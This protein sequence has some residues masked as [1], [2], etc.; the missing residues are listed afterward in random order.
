MGIVKADAYGHGLL[1][2][3]RSLVAGGVDLLGVAYVHEG[4]SLREAGIRTPVVILCGAHGSD[5]IQQS[6]EKDLMP[7]LLDAFG[8]E[9]LARE[10]ERRQKTATVL[11]K[12]DTG[13]GRLGIPSADLPWIL[14][15]L[16]GLRSLR[17]KGLI[18]HLS[19]ADDPD[20]GF[21]HGQISAFQAAIEKGRAMG[22]DLTLNSLANS[23]G[24]IRFRESHFD[25]VRP[26]ILLYGGWPTDDQPRLSSLRTAMRLCGHILQI[27]DLPENTPISYGRTFVTRKATRVAVVSAG[28]GDGLPRHMS[29]H[30]AVL[31]GGKR[32]SILGTICMNLLVSELSGDE[33]AKPGDEVVFLG[34]QD[35][36]TITGDELARWSS[37]IPYEVFCSIGRSHERTY[38]P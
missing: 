7:V 14:E 35:H 3:S 18:S 28:Y 36:E 38:H 12:V 23:A 24:I 13:M 33:D 6:L 29:N 16:R 30:G 5:E 21:T 34:T 26:G 9:C 20:A 19:S 1:P 37:T 17:L 22:L 15:R 32:R 11:L 2:A 10:C 4:L 31:I 8:A 27:R 25:M